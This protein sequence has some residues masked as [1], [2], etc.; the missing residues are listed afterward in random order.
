M[1]QK[2]KEF[3]NLIGQA[4][5]KH[6]AVYKVLPSLTIAQII[7]ESNWGTSGLAKTCFNYTGMKWTVGCG[8]DYKE[9]N[10]KEWDKKLNTYVTVRAKF[11]KFKNASEGIEGHYKF[12]HKYKRYSLIIGETSSIIA[13]A[14]MGQSGWATA[15][16]YG[17]SLWNDYVVKYNLTVWDDIVLNGGC[18][19]QQI[20]SYEIG[21]IYT[22]QV[23][24][25]VRISANGNKAKYDNLTPDGKKNSRF[26][27]YG[28]AIL[29]KGTRV[30]CRN[31]LQLPTSTW[32]EIPSGW[33]CAISNGKIY[34]K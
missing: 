29:N 7:K 15:P 17:S 25:N 4:A 14:K 6:Y 13:C 30:T 9:Y 32:I 2:Q 8:Y 26:D 20:N 24:L 10:T 19:P 12:L 1:T 16:N 27:D 3:I 34:I 11:I 28:N 22:T 18:I 21:K 33:I 5:I 23:D 31:V